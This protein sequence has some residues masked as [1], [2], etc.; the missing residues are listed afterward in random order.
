MVQTAIAPR[1]SHEQTGRDGGGQ[2]DRAETP[3]PTESR[4]PLA[5]REH[6]GRSALSEVRPLRKGSH[7]WWLRG[8][9]VGCHGRNLG[10]VAG[11]SR[12]PPSP[13]RQDGVRRRAVRNAVASRPPSSHPLIGCSSIDRAA[14]R[15]SQCRAAVLPAKKSGYIAGPCLMFTHPVN[16]FRRGTDARTF[17]GVC[18][19]ST[20][21]HRPSM[22][23]SE[24]GVAA[25]SY[26]LPSATTG[27]RFRRNSSCGPD[28]LPPLPGTGS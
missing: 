2:D 11:P 26:V 22:D 18:A 19:V 12:C 23:S 1:R 25:L 15:Q 7:R 24:N 3:V 16:R 10:R 9:R 28:R 6:R 14:R 20:P 27:P 17:D 5:H 8:R 21:T 4:A 13:T